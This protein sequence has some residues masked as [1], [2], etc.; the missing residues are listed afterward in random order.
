[1]VL[2]WVIVTT[3]D[4]LI[5]YICP[6]LLKPNKT[7]NCQR[8]LGCDTRSLEMPKDDN[9]ISLKDSTIISI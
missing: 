2:T 5:A 8:P 4:N 7:I 1:M 3:T 6:I 9:Q